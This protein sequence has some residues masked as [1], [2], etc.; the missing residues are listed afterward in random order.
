MAYR[1]V[2]EILSKRKKCVIY[3]RVSSER[4]V[5]GF[6]LD[7]QKRE[8]TDYAKILGYEVQNIYIE[9]GKSGKNI[10]GRDEFQRM[11]YDVTRP[12]SE[13]G[14]VLVYKLSRF[15]RNTRDILNSINMLS[16]YGV[17]LLTKEEG[18]DSSNTTGKMLIAIL[19]TIAE[20]ERENIVVQTMLGREE[21]AKQGG[22][23][24][25]F[26]PLGYSI[27]DEKLVPNE[28][29][30]IVKLIFQKYVNEDIGIKGIVDYLNKN[31]IK[32][33]KIKNRMD[34]QFDDWSTHTIKHILD[35]PIYTGFVYF[36]RRRTKECINDE[37]GAIE[38]KL[39]KQKEEDYICSDVQAHEALVSKEDFEKAKLKRKHRACKG[40]R[41]I[42]QNPRHLLSGVL[43]CPDCG[44]K[45]VINYNKWKN[46]DGTYHETRT[47]I[48]GH[49]NR[50][51]VHG[52]CKR[53]GICADWIEKEVVEYTKALVR[54]EIFISDVKE[55]IGTS[56]D[57]SEL[58]KEIVSLDKKIKML[59][60]N[61]ES[62]EKEIDNI[63]DDDK[64]A[65]KKRTDMNKR[66]NKIYEQISDFEIERQETKDKMEAVL[67]EQLNEENI[68]QKL[69]DFDKVY[70]TLSDEDKRKLIQTFISKIEIYKKSEVKGRKSYIK[71]IRYAFDIEHPDVNLGNKGN[72]VETVC[73]LSKLHEA[74]HHVNVALDM[75]EIDI[76]SAESKVTYE[77]I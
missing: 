8:L 37:T 70:D 5:Q 50:S 42:G 20:M 34:Y 32:K 55:K 77:E 56:I 63:F 57:V 15:G 46:K 25:G 26:A 7:G 1:M 69:L 45:M 27:V 36:G 72:D 11:L 47:Y 40:N 43:V 73:L 30:Y 28:H 29:A 59:L 9:E 14:Y 48:C 60:R 67:Q 10:E 12:D 31:G 68:Y 54:N 58:K 64:I 44:S 3:I 51:G 76:T 6:S 65:L 24:G 18:L 52:N 41:N 13:V 62:L 16:S 23:N 19:G 4:Q 71:K 53:N 2:S 39:L 22:W 35:N 49:Y 17:H 61:K 75:D 21:K 33:P 38:Y 66:L 74:K